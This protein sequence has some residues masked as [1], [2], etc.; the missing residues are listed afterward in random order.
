MGIDKLATYTYCGKAQKK[1]YKIKKGRG[2]IRVC[3]VYIQ[4]IHLL[5]TANKKHFSKYCR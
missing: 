3:A 4:S 5:L 1:K 2:F